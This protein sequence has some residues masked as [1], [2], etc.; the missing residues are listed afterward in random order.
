MTSSATARASVVSLRDVDA[1]VT[2]RTELAASERHYRLLAENS[3]DVIMHMRDRVVAW[4]SPG[5]V[6]ALGWTASE[7]VG[8]T[9]ESLVHADDAARIVAGTL[10]L[11]AGHDVR[12][13]MRWLRPDGS[14]SWFDVAAR[15]FLDDGVPDGAVLRLRDV[16]DEV[17]SRSRLEYQARHDQLTGLVNRQ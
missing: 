14:S 6:Q 9:M 2:T 7:L 5:V 15:Y 16:H 8:R 1:E 17:E 13:T 3:A 10:D 4:V 11:R 12:H